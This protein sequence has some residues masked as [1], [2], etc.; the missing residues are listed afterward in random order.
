MEF[1]FLIESFLKIIV[2]VI[3]TGFSVKKLMDIKDEV[4]W[5][6]DNIIFATSLIIGFVLGIV[7]HKYLK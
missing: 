3:S 1:I 6:N 4:D 5:K 2:T 7:W